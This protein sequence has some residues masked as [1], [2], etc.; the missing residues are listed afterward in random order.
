MGRVE[1]YSSGAR[2]INGGEMKP[3]RVEL[4]FG[5]EVACVA[6]IDG[7]VSQGV[8]ETATAA[9]T[10]MSLERL[11]D[12]ARI[13]CAH[14]VVWAALLVTF[15]SVL[16]GQTT[17]KHDTNERGTWHDIGDRGKGKEFAQ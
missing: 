14:G 3:L 1:E 15:E 16:H 5:L 12:A 9:T 2:K 13:D 7:V 11:A 4:N 8:E 10:V 6:A 17:T